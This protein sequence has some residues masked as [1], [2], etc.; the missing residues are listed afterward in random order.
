[1]PQGE[2]TDASAFV[3]QSAVAISDRRVWMCDSGANDHLTGDA[4]HVFNRKAPLKGQEWVTIGDGTVMKV[5]YVGALNVELHGDTDVGVQ[6]PSVY[7]VDGLAINLFSLDAVKAKHPIT[8]DSKGV[9]LFGGKITF[10]RGAS[11]SFF[12]CYTTFPLAPSHTG[13]SYFNIPPLAPGRTECPA[14]G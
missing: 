9:H 5:L 13:C 6:L 1:M 10:P 3:G 8:L 11:G 2:F 7:V 12:T 4:K 14:Y